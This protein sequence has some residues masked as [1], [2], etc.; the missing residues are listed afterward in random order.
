MLHHA[1]K[2]SGAD[3]AK[4]FRAAAAIAQPDIGDDLERFLEDESMTTPAAWDLEEVPTGF[5]Q[6]GRSDYAPTRDLRSAIIG[7]AGII[8]RD[9][10]EVQT[11]A[12]A[13]QFPADLPGIRGVATVRTSW[14]N[15]M[16]VYL[17]EMSDDAAAKE[18][19]EAKRPGARVGIAR[20][21]LFVL[22][23]AE[24]DTGETPEKLQRFVAPIERVLDGA[25][26]SK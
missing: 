2:R 21:N 11:V 10:Y 1:A 25:L 17:V 26:Q 9:P 22:I 15:S 5:I 6:R 20:G 3:P 12:I 8:D 18:L 19:A 13:D 24:D 16:T 14:Q 4:L 7:I 23:H